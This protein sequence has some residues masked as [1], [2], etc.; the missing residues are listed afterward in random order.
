MESEEIGRRYYQNIKAIKSIGSFPMLK[1][2][3]L[4]DLGK[5]NDMLA[6]V[7]R[8]YKDIRTDNLE[9]EGKG[10]QKLDISI[11][12]YLCMLAG[13]FL[14]DMTSN[15]QELLLKYSSHKEAVRCFLRYFMKDPL[16]Y[17]GKYD[18]EKFKEIAVFWYKIINEER[19]IK[20]K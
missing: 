3:Q 17:L 12:D 15:H 9:R 6:T 2:L 5:D 11:I 16:F 20:R 19:T 7:Q 8:C 10:D 18:E 13:L 14:A 4:S 1:S